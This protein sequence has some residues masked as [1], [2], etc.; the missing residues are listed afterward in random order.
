MF[1]TADLQ[2]YNDNVVRGQFE[3]IPISFEVEVVGEY[4]PNED[5]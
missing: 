5:N 2:A 4:I 1:T 3:S